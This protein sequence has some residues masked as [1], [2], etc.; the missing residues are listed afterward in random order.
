MLAA[1][2]RSKDV[3]LI[4]TQKAANL[5]FFNEVSVHVHILCN[6]GCIT[7]DKM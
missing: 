2:N 4:L 1:R 5:D 7:E 6:K 3:V